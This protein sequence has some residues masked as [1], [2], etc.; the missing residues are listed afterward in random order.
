[1][2][3]DDA[4]ARRTHCDRR[5]CA[6][7]LHRCETPSI[8]RSWRRGSLVILPVPDADRVVTIGTFRDLDNPGGRARDDSRICCLE[9][10]NRSFESMGTSITLHQDLGAETSRRSHPEHLVG[11]AV[12]PS[13]FDVLKVQPHLGRLFREDEA[14]LERHGA[15]GYFE[16][17]PL[18]APVCGD[19]I[20]SAGRFT[21]MGGI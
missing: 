2:A 19:R 17:S 12:T 14:R 3:C 7:S 11:Q 13:L 1:M 15:R 4:Q 16:P 20:L 9:E 5:D 21:W 8:L 6:G 10:R 18:A